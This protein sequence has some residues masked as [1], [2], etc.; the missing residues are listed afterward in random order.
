MKITLIILNLLAALILVPVTMTALQIN[1]IQ[2]AASTYDQLEKAHAI[3]RDQVATVFPVAAHNNVD[4]ACQFIGPRK[5]ITRFGWPISAVFC[6]NAIMIGL[7]MG[8]K[9]KAES[10]ISEMK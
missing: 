8:R 2:Y 9:P 4:M 7:F 1:R 10:K 5:N 6:L 3:D